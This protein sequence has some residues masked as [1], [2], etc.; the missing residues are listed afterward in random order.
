MDIGSGG[1]T[2]VGMFSKVFSSAIDSFFANK[3]ADK[4][5]GQQID[6]WE[7]QNQYNLPINQVARLKDAGLNPALMYGSGSGANTAGYL[8][9]VPERK[10]S[11]VDSLDLLGKQL[12]VKRAEAE[13]D[14]L[15]ANTDLQNRDANLRQ[16]QTLNAQLEEISKKIQ[17]T[18]SEEELELFRAQ[19]Q[20]L[21]EQ[22]KLTN[23]NIKQD[24]QLKADQ[25]FNQVMSAF[26][27]YMS[28][29]L[30]G[31]HMELVDSQI[32]ELASRTGLNRAHAKHFAQLVANG[33]LEEIKHKYNHALRMLGVDP[34]NHHWVQALP[35]A[36]VQ[37]TNAE[38]FLPLFQGTDMEAWA[39]ALNSPKNPSHAPSDVPTISSSEWRKY[40]WR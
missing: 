23:A 15:N 38:F 14:N 21:I 10:I 1:S 8:S 29:N 24:T 36:F 37:A 20:D 16:Q 35:R 18:K 3:M 12:A 39:K 17:N 26:Q 11:G 34:D 13:V 32:D 33:K 2:A 9:S 22:L 19:K 6:F 25:Q 7:R 31:K 27:A 30:S 40:A 4:Q 5:Y 28:G